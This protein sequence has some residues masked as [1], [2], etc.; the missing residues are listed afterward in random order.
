MVDPARHIVKALP[1]ITH[2]ISLGVDYD[3]TNP[4]AGLLDP[5]HPRHLLT[6]P[7]MGY[8]YRP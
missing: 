6:E 1:G 4:I 2:W 7:G 5:A 8:H 3:T